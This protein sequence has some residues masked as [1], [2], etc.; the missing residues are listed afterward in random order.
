MSFTNMPASKQTPPVSTTILAT[1]ASAMLQDRLEQTNA[2]KTF[3][4]DFIQDPKERNSFYERHIPSAATAQWLLVSGRTLFKTLIHSGLA[5]ERDI[6]AALLCFAL[7]ILY[8]YATG[9]GS[10]KQVRFSL[11]KIF[12]LGS[13]I[14]GALTAVSFWH[15]HVLSPQ[16]NHALE[17]NMQWA[18][19]IVDVLGIVSPAVTVALCADYV[20]NQR[21]MEKQQPEDKETKGNKKKQ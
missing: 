21:L 7:F 19:R 5:E 10:W 1:S 11:F 6:L 20:V 9:G 8:L 14:L 17:V 12:C 3:L 16:R 15:D 18:E 13:G 4:E 2:R